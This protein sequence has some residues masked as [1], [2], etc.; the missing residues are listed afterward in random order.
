MMK[1][2]F[3]IVGEILE[4]IFNPPS[5]TLGAILTTTV[6]G[7]SYLSNTSLFG[8]SLKFVAIVCIVMVVDWCLGVYASVMAENKKFSEKRLT[9]TI[10][11]FVT[12]FM[13][14]YFV[15]QIKS[16]YESIKWAYDTVLV[17]QVF[18]LILIGL[19][20]FVSIGDNIE[21]IWGVK[22]YLFTL[23]DNLFH[24]MEKLFKKKI[25]KTID[26]YVDDED[27]FN[28]DENIKQEP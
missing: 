12:F 14:L 25:E 20:E 19:R 5:I 16:E 26:E 10:L 11:K 18:V 2:Q 13:F 22:P 3:Q 6:S 15:N 21:R 17:I 27:D 7:Y 4:K 28:E 24:I 1:N 23:I 8:V 9:Y